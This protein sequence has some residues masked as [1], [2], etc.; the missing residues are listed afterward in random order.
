MRLIEG[1]KAKGIFSCQNKRAIK[2]IESLFF[3]GRGRGAVVILALRGWGQEDF[4]LKPNTH[5]ELKLKK[6]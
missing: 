1:N 3:R 6:E 4:K 2:Y 5:N